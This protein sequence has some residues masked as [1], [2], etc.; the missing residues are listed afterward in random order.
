M[1]SHELLNILGELSRSTSGT[2]DADTRRAQF[3][4]RLADISRAVVA[5]LEQVTGRRSFLEQATVYVDDPS[6]RQSAAGIVLEHRFHV[7]DDL[8]AR[9]I[10]L[11]DHASVSLSVSRSAT[12]SEFG[13]IE[14][15]IRSVDRSS[16]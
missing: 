8:T 2:V 15:C 3:W 16:G 14:E 1:P 10:C 6:F 7:S 5:D 13:R 4:A 12:S 9:T 11:V